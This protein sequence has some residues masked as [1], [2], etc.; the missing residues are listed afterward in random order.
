MRIAIFTETYTPYISGLVTSEIMLK[1]ALEAQGHEV[2]V[3]T[4]NLESF[5]Y[6]YDEKEKVLKIPGIPTGI[7][8][9]RL[10]SIYPVRAVNKIKS[11]KLDVIHSQTEFGV[12][13]FS[14]VCS[15]KLHI[16]VVHTY[17]TLYEDYVY[18]ITH[19]HFD[20]FAKKMVVR[21]TRYYC[22]KKCNE[23]I[24]PTNKIKDLFVNKYKIN[25]TIHVIPT[26][27]DIKKFAP[28]KE[29]RSK[30]QN[31]RKKYKIKITDFVI[32]SVGRIAIEKS[33]DKLINATAE[34]LK[35]NPNIKLMLVGDGPA[36]EE[37]KKQVKE[38]D[39]EKN[40]IF[41]G[42]VDYNDIPAY[43]QA[44]DV[45][46]SFSITETQGL[47]II[48][49]LAASK[50]TLCINDDSFKAMIQD[51]YNGYL[52][53]DENDF[54]KKT[55]MLMNDKEL[56]KE[57]AKNAKNSTYQYSKEVFGSEVLKVYHKAIKSIKK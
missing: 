16:P 25:K 24:V 38:L 12:G 23:L 21:I 4:A 11:W 29:L 27:I 32:G 40:V 17:H 47:T 20:N 10:S 7:Y 43:Y 53:K 52:F 8:D 14:R 22:D 15:K 34:M 6:E 56:Y 31:I 33:F 46:V 19:G 41:T 49:G 51:S 13:Y 3:V 30:A 36:I 57:M 28:S 39:I 37:L 2:Y 9:S 50:P 44:L 42:L 45:M 54:I 26:G 5:K 48:E 1:K 55:F 18:Y 35:V